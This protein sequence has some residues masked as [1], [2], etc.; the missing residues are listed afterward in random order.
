MSG[1]PVGPAGAE[2]WVWMAW[3]GVRALVELD[4]LTHVGLDPIRTMPPEFARVDSEGMALAVIRTATR[5]RVRDRVGAALDCIRA[6]VA[7]QDASRQT[8]PT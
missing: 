5:A 4:A 1:L 3:G 6:E 8:E 7:R 2:R